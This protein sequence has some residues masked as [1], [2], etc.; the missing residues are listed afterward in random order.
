MRGSLREQLQP[1]RD[2]MPRRFW[3]D[4]KVKHQSRG[5]AEAHARSL[6]RRFGNVDVTTYYCVTCCKWHVGNVRPQRRSA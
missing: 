2:A 6:R 1:I 5:S 3:C 4:G